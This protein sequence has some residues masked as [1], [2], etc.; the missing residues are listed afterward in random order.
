MFKEKILQYVAETSNNIFKSLRGKGKITEKQLKYFTIAHKKATNLGKIY[1]LPKIHK[2]LF[3]VPGRPFISNCGSTTEKVSEILD[4]H[5]KGIM[6]ES[7]SYIKD[8]NDFIRK[9]KDIPQDALLVTA[10]VVGLY[11]ST[12]HEAGLKALKKALDKRENSHE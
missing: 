9:T 7:W 4:S 11:P 5:L 2:R 6:Q 8:S 3:N 12:L 10:D 1:L